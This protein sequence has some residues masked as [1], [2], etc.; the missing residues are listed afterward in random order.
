MSTLTL[1]IIVIIYMFLV[2]YLGYLG[3]KAT[4]DASD[5]L[6]GGRKVNPVIMALSYGATF[7]SASAIVGFGGIAATFG[8]GIQWLCLLNM[9]MGVIIAFIVFGRKTRKMGAEHNAKTFPQ[10]LGL[11]YNSRAIQI[12]IAGIIFIGMPLYTA[13]VM[14]GGAVFIEQ[15]FEIDFHV[16]LLAFTLIV[17]AYVISGG[18]KGVLYTDALQAVIMFV[19]MLFLL[20]W[21]YKSMDLGFVEANKQLSDLAPLVP[22]KY[23]LLGHQGWTRMPV[24]GSPQWFTLVTSLILGVGLGCLAQPQLVVRFMM[25][26]SSKQINRGVLIGCVFLIIT[27]GAIYHVGA[28]SNLFFYKT[29][30]LVAS[31]AVKDIDKI[32]PLFINKAMPD[33][34]GALFMLCILSASMSTLSAL[35]H[36][37]GAAFGAD[38]F[39]KLGRRKNENSTMGVRIGVLISILL[40]YIIC[41]TLSAGIIAR[42]TALFMGVCAVTFLPAYFCSLYWPKVTRQGAIASLFTGA[43]AS[44]FAMLF[45]HKAEAVPV[46]LCKLLFGKEVLVDIYPW[47]AIDPILFALPLSVVAIVSVSLLTQPKR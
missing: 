37:M 21:F 30:G 10:L 15:M 44:M 23:K 29:Q 14:K 38:M 4:K 35:F 9:F 33:W 16:A 28:L 17:A 13:V 47:F 18:I 19:C 22:E 32:I 36:T 42:G 45:L 8:M 27:V 25:V 11:H 43:F 7:I 34:F 40:S 46:G 5:Y 6:L 39:P 24:T 12:F 41:Y 31:E 1:G 20:F 26:E 3:Y 2:A